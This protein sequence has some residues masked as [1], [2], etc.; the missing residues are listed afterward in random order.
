MCSIYHKQFGLECAIARCFAFVGPYLP[1]DTHF[2][3]GNFIRDAMRGGPVRVGGDGTPYRSYLYAADLAI[4]LWT[5]LLRGVPC[6]P[7]NTGAERDLTI[8]E[9]AHVVAATLAIPG[10]VKIAKTPVPGAQP[11]RYVPSTERARK[12]LSLLEWISLEDA[13]QSTAG[14]LAT[15]EHR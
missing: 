12:E 13:I 4:W 15:D 2:A 11:E 3:I 1:L 14:R 5:I 10:N 8:A 9:L 7:Y 6:R